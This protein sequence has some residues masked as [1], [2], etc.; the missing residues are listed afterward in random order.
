[1]LSSEKGKKEQARCTSFEPSYL[2][3]QWAKR[4]FRPAAASLTVYKKVRTK[5]IAYSKMCRLRNKRERK[6]YR[7]TATI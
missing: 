3:E 4:L 5:K 2:T 1:V 6:I 7:F